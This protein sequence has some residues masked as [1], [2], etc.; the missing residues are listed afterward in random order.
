[1]SAF[2][3]YYVGGMLLY[4]LNRLEV[5]NICSI[6]TV[7]PN[8]LITQFVCTLRTHARYTR[9]IIVIVCGSKCVTFITQIS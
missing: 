1:M 5:V 4:V 7:V 2:L 9:F 8:L 6:L 3:F